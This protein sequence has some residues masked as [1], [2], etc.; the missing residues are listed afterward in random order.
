MNYNE[1][2]SVTS[3]TDSPLRWGRAWGLA[4]LM[5]AT[6]LLNYGLFSSALQN[7]PASQFWVSLLAINGVFFGLLH[8]V[9]VHVVLPALRMIRHVRAIYAIMSVDSEPRGSQAPRTRG[10][11][12]IGHEFS[13]FTELSL[14]YFRR[15]QEL[16]S[17]LG[18]AQAILA[19]FALH[20]DTFL[21]STSREIGTQYRAVLAYANYLEEQIMRNRLNPSLRYDFDEVCESSFNL[22]LIAGAL[23]M[24]SVEAPP[25]VTHVTLADVMRRT[26]LALAPAL[27][28]RAMRISSAEVN[29]Y[30]M[31]YGDPGFIAHILWM[32]LLGMVRYAADESTLRIRCFYNHDETRAMMSIVVTELKRNDSDLPSNAPSALSGAGGV[33]ATLFAEAIRIHANIQLAHLLIE[34]MGGTITVLPLTSE[35]CEI[36]MDLPV[37][38]RAHP[39][40]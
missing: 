26:L 8:L 9:R 5:I 6:L 10:R 4:Q 34:R 31:A 23:A 1:I 18:E 2:S 38:K 32:M 11:R 12:G 35:S 19:Q 28:R 36:F 14:Q 27:D 21:D 13:R 17:E 30:V 37:P 3:S 25:H 16:A 7:L 29:E 20:Q 22:K 33:T 15:H 24:L 39:F 40:V